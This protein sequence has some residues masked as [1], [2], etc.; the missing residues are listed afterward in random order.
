MN[1]SSEG[2]QI[3]E[4]FFLRGENHTYVNAREV[5]G[6]EIRE[7]EGSSP[8]CFVIVAITANGNTYRMSNPYRTPHLDQLRDKL[9]TAIWLLGNFKQAENRP[10]PVFASA[11]D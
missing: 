4:N 5:Q 3:I 6:F 9:R 1:S 8:V 2:F 7:A 11:S 10:F